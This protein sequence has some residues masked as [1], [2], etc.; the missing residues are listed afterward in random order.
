MAGHLNRLLRV[1][2]SRRSFAEESFPDDL[3]HD[4]IGGRGIGAR[5]LYDDV[6]AGLDPLEESSEIIFLAGP[7]AGS[8][9]QCFSRLLVFFKSPLTGGYFR[10]TSGGSFAPEMKFAGFDAVAVT[11]RAEKPVYL[12]LHDGR[13]ELRDA[14]YLQGLGCGDTEHLIRDELHDPGVRVAAIGPAG[15]NLVR[16]AGIFTDRHTAGRGGGGTVMGA[17]NLKAIAVRGHG[18][19]PIADPDAFKAACREQI[20]DIQGHSAYPLMSSRGRQRSSFGLEL[21]IY[22]TRNF[23]AGTLPGWE[24]IADEVYDAMRVRNTTCH[25]CLVH[26]HSLTKVSQGEYAGTWSEGPEYQSIWSF[27][28][29]IGCTDP[30]LTVAADR[31]CDDMGLDTISAGGCI[32]FAYELFERDIITTADTGGL[33]LTYGSGAPVLKLLIDI[34][35]RRGLGD[36]LADGV[37]AAA[38]RLGRGS[39]PYAMHVKGL[40]I[41]GYDPRGAKAHGLN[42]LTGVLGAQHMTGYV[43]HEIFPHRFPPEKRVDRFTVE[44]KG[45]L[46]K[47]YQDLTT[48]REVGALCGTITG[49]AIYGR[50]LAAATGNAGFADTAYLAYVGEKIYNL[51][52]MFN[53][54]EGFGRGDDVFPAR[55]TDEALPDG[56]SAGYFFESETL[57]D[58]YYTARG[59]DM[60]TGNP[61]PAKLRELGLDFAIAAPV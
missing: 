33:E 28:G 9:A 59:W 21:G 13:Y 51:E 22:P 15:E 31:L 29:P 52:R 12:W 23:R 27:S 4:Y 37:R 38:Q 18:A 8:G 10:S 60:G 6:P 32:G 19:V 47:F 20:A 11:G 1:D 55:I 48:W 17:K 43:T 5:L 46:C 24:S 50:L 58:D 2:L 54:R 57:L 16:Y 14:A 35:A 41:S 34:V 30:G 45:E 40:E 3:L 25:R 39:E 56:P 42:M 7:L 36:L 53:A 49:D 26:C 44:G 61:T